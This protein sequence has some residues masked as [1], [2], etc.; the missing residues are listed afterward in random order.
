MISFVQSV[1]VSCALMVS[2]GSPALKSQALLKIGNPCVDR[3]QQDLVAQKLGEEKTQTHKSHKRC[4]SEDSRAAKRCRESAPHHKKRK[5]H[6]RKSRSSQPTESQPAESQ[7]RRLRRAPC[8]Y[9]DR[10]RC[11]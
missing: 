3:C 11:R 9:I 6:H 10:R 5:T 4:S 1:I 2:T 7:P 8:P